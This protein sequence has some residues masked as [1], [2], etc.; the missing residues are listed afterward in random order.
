MSTTFLEVDNISN[1]ESGTSEVTAFLLNPSPLLSTAET[2]GNT[3]TDNL[4]LT[5]G[6]HLSRQLTTPLVQLLIGQLRPNRPGT[7][8]MYGFVR[9]RNVT[10]Q[11]ITGGNKRNVVVN[12]GKKILAANGSVKTFFKK[13]STFPLLSFF[14]ILFI[15]NQRLLMNN[16]KVLEKFFIWEENNSTDLNQNLLKSVEQD[17]SVIT[18]ETK[19]DSIP[20]DWRDI[21]DPKL[22]KKMRKRINDKKYRKKHSEKIKSYKKFLYEKNKKNKTSY[23]DLNKDKT[24]IKNKLYRKNNKEKINKHNRNKHK[25]NVQ[26]KLS[27]NLRNRLN[28]ALKNNYKSVSAV[29]DLG[30]TVEELKKYLESKFS[31]GMT[32]DNWTID[33]WHIDHIKPLSSFD[34]TDRNQLL[35]ACHYTNLQP[36]WA[37]DNLS[38]GAKTV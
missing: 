29:R 7:K 33:G 19:T 15:Y 34:L 20:K 6:D 11:I 14:Y 27:I 25:T 9:V 35:E 16:T 23:Y 3:V 18:I 4:L 12:H 31:P 1:G 37:K 8:T 2:T 24:L 22:R 28:D 32:W 38:K 10:D 21:T 5:V 17:N 30:C 36:L 13:F 26:F